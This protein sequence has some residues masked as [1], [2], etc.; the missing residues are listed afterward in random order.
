V[1]VDSDIY[2]S[3]V[4]V[5]PQ[6]HSG[7]LV[8]T[9]NRIKGKSFARNLNNM[10]F[11][12]DARAIIRTHMVAAPQRNSSN[13]FYRAASNQGGSFG[14]DGGANNQAEQTINQAGGLFGGGIAQGQAGEGDDHY[15]GDNKRG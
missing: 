2:P 4:Q 3:L 11:P 14:E 15:G 12:S 10:K 13:S 8:K 5:K 9:I 7:L 1:F 6:E